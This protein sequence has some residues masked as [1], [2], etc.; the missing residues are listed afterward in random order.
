MHHGTNG[1]SRT[2]KSVY[3]IT[4]MKLPTI[5]GILQTITRSGPRLGLALSGGG[6][7]GFSHIGVV[8]ALERFGLK[9]SICAGV[10]AGSIAAAMYGAGFTGAQMRDCFIEHLRFGDFKEWTMPRD[11]LMSLRRFEKLLRQWL[12]TQK[13][14]EM[15]I[16]TYICATNLDKGVSTG[17]SAGDTVQA[18]LA[19]CSI[20]VLFPPV[21]I[22]GVHYI[23][24]GV[25]RNL[26]AWAIRDKCDILLGSNCNPLDR[27]YR[28]RSSILSIALRSYQLVMK[29]N[30]LQDLEK[31]DY[32]I[33]NRSLSRYSTF[34]VKE[35]D[36]I[37][38]EGYEAALPVVD[39]I[40]NRHYR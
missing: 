28:Y 22:N 11:G 31:C 32:V 30:V 1:K 4:V 24:G 21:R 19:S 5:N 2:A 10:S 23:D 34:S 15:Q 8:L 14:E 39:E 35:M 37:I 27:N 9:A 17:F 7:R 26:P 16:P 40:A 33:Q 36:R 38:L 13:L 20:P 3:C 12:P 6:A 29:G 18:V 25:L